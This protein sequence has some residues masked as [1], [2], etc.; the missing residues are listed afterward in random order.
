MA[1]LA[2]RV[3]RVEQGLL[4]SS[5]VL[6]VVGASL[7]I[8]AVSGCRVG[9]T[10]CPTAWVQS[11]H[12]LLRSFRLAVLAG[13]LVGLSFLGFLLVGALHRTHGA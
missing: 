9:A 11:L 3:R 5:T 6:L 12:P 8:V 2:D 13:T 4:V 10:A 7:A 1:W